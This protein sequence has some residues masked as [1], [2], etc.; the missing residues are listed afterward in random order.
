MHWI[1]TCVGVC[2]VM[3][4]S[5][6][7][8]VS[9]VH[10]DRYKDMRELY[11]EVTGGA[12]SGRV[13]AVRAEDRPYQPTDSQPIARPH[14]T[15]VEPYTRNVQNE[16]NHLFTR[17]PNP[18]IYL[19]VDPHLSGNQGVPIPGYTTAFPMYERD[20]WAL[21][22]EAPVPV[23]STNSVHQPPSGEPR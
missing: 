3:A 15:P 7:N 8:A 23:W 4:L 6:C 5:G 2:L 10:D 16:I 21:P 18:T 19:Y 14:D 20:H 11:D 1:K 13:G 12:S 9:T 17:L 22:G